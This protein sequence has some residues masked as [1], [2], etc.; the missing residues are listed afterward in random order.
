M[1]RS[2]RAFAFVAF[3]ALLIVTCNNAWAENDANAERFSQLLAKKQFSQAFDEINQKLKDQPID[4]DANLYLWRGN[5]YWSICDYRNA[6]ADYNKALSMGSSGT[7]IDALV[8][9]GI[10]Q[11]RLGDDCAESFLHAAKLAVEFKTTDAAQI[12]TIGQALIELQRKKELLEFTSGLR[13]VDGDAT[14]LDALDATAS[15]A[16]AKAEITRRDKITAGMTSFIATPHCVLISDIKKDALERYATIAEGFINYVNDNLYS[17]EGNYPVSI[18]ILHDKAA[19]QAFLRNHMNFNMHVQ[20]VYISSRNVL[21]TFD[22]TGTGT[23]LHEIMHKI[24]EGEKH[25]EFWAEEGIPAYFEKVYGKLQPQFS[26]EVGFPENWY[27]KAI[28]EN[29]GTFKLADIVGKA[30]HADPFNQDRQRLVAL[31]LNR[32]GKLKVYLTLVKSGDKKGFKTFVEAAFEKPMNELAPLFQSYL[33]E[34]V[35]DRAKIEK[36]P[37]S[38]IS[39]GTPHVR[40]I[41]MFKV[42]PERHGS[43]REF[44]DGKCDSYAGYDAR[45]NR[46]ISE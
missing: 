38:R 10:C 9:K 1:G 24:L 28:K 43:L 27:P 25:L 23:L 21:V 18:F 34:I 33:Q 30:K 8:H 40:D 13:A 37:E 22:G 14:L 16:T 11:A 20:G 19:E 3:C 2:S 5:T 6:I 36:Q 42:E 35:K 17:V 26:I 29:A 7:N 45:S 31:F 39:L 44:L 15:G 41:D 46:Y 12:K 4:N 32:Y